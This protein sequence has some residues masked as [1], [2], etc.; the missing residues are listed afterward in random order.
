MSSVSQSGALC[1]TCTTFD[2]TNN[3]TRPYHPVNVSPS[4]VCVVSVRVHVS[5]PSPASHAS[6]RVES[7]PSVCGH[8]VHACT[9][10]ITTTVQGTHEVH[11]YDLSEVQKKNTAML[12][13]KKCEILCVWRGMLVLPDMPVGWERCVV[14]GI[15]RTRQTTV[16]L[17][18]PE[19]GINCPIMET[20]EIP[21]LVTGQIG[22]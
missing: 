4:R 12:E 1:T 19:H 8:G 13:F 18:V 2:S 10:T 9:S 5:P 11:A 6:E 7:A 14:Q 20:P 21:E 22:T 15:T 17:L 3:T 16:D